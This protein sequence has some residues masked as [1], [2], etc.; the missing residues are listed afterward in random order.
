MAECW[1]VNSS[2]LISLDRIGLL[3]ILGRLGRKVVIP[4]GVL[5]EIA[6]GPAPITP[7]RLAI[8]QTVDISA[9][10]PIVAGWDL[11]RGESEVLTWAAS[12]RQALAILDDLAARRCAASLGIEPHGTLFVLLEAKKAGIVP[13]VAP[14]IELA[15]AKGLF[16]SDSLVVKVLRRAGETR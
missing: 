5:D 14:L 7:N 16:V 1:I 2:P 15:R 3:D 13:A 6:R 11:G 9:I 4:R 8:H 10:D 12:Q